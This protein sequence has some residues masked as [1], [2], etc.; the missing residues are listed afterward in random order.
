M[1]PKIGVPQN[2]WFTM[3]NPIKIDDLG[4]PLLLDT[5][6][7]CNHRLFHRKRNGSMA[8]AG[9]CPW[10]D[11]VWQLDYWGNMVLHLLVKR[12]GEVPSQS[13]KWNLK[14]APW[15]RRFVLE[16]IILGFHVKLG[17]CICRNTTGTYLF[18]PFLRVQDVA[19]KNQI[20]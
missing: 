17:E 5:S 10:D 16:A 20:S 11:C 9:A 12:I 18:D 2:G 15:N 13:L 6:I 19:M 8:S 1:F 4:V 7:S 14:M 3:E